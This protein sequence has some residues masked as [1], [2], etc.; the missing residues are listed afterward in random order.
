MKGDRFEKALV[1]LKLSI[2]DTI[3]Q[4]GYEDNLSKFEVFAVV[5]CGEKIGFF[6]YHHDESNLDEEDIPHFEGMVSHT[7]SY[8]IGEDLNTIM[9]P[10]DIPIDLEK[11]YHDDKKLKTLTDPK[12]QEIRNKAKQYEEPCIFN[13]GKHAK[14]IEY[15]FNHIQHEQA[16]TSVSV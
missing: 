8:K 1:Q 15:L 9:D 2:E 10:E 4:M 6:E 13:I 5:M 3:S 16:R 12:Q 11:L 14:E 7:T